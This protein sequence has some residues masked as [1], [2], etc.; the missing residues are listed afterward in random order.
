MR[1]DCPNCRP[2]AKKLEEL[3]TLYGGQLAIIAITNPPDAPANVMRFVS[4]MKVTYPVLFDCG[5]V[6]FSYVRPSPLKPSI[7]IPHVYLVDR[8]GYIRQDF[9]FGPNTAELFLGNGLRLEIDKLIAA[10]SAKP[11]TGA[12]KKQ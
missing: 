11:A 5:Q 10:T 3:K 7:N 9:E 2:F 6:A 12:R 1:T 8:G 4:E